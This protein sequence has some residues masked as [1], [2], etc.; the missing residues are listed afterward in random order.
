M[1]PCVSAAARRV[2]RPQMK[3]TSPTWIT[4]SPV[5]LRPWP[6]AL[7]PYLPGIAG[8]RHRGGGQGRNNW[9]VWTGGNDRMW[10]TLATKSVGLLD[11]LKDRVESP[12]P[13][14]QPRQPLEVSRAGGTSPVS[15]GQRPARRSLWPVARRAARAARP[16][17]SRTRRNT[18]RRDR[19]ARKTVPVGSYYGLRHRHRR[20]AAV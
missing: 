1:K 7:E 12:E 18:R 6:A 4:A 3:T 10:D 11:L 8:R 14:L 15:T 5:I 20:P 17:R 16:T 19:R 9:I 2:F 13:E